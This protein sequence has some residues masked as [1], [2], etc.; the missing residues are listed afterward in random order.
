MRARGQFHLLMWLAPLAALLVHGPSAAALQPSPRSVRVQVVEYRSCGNTN[1]SV[2]QDTLAFDV[3][4][5]QPFAVDRWTDGLRPRGWSSSLTLGSIVGADQAWVRIH[6]LALEAPR[7]NDCLAVPPA[8]S[9]LLTTAWST[10]FGKATRAAGLVGLRIR[11]LPSPA[12]ATMK[13]EQRLDVRRRAGVSLGVL[14]VES[15]ACGSV[16]IGKFRL[17][18]VHLAAP[19]GDSMLV[20]P[21]DAPAAS[22]TELVFTPMELWHGQLPSTD[23]QIHV[24][25]PPGPATLRSWTPGGF[26]TPL[27]VGQ[28]AILFVSIWTGVEGTPPLEMDGRHDLCLLD[29][30]EHL[31]FG[32]GRRGDP[33]EHLRA[34][35]ERAL[36]PRTHPGQGRVVGIVVRDSGPPDCSKIRLSVLGTQFETGLSPAGAFDLIGVPTGTRQIRLTEMGRSATGTIEV[37]EDP[38]DTLEVHFAGRHD[39]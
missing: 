34:D 8:D 37:T 7:R 12:L 33:V 11:L 21:D 39:H 19:A 10:F 6:E 38:T 14:P 32:L 1:R 29:A 5:L 9:V 26:V 20:V 17:D 15:A 27:L 24:H 28:S 22:P 31:A 30:S 23:H 3:K 16:M 25:V 35:V 18:E 2:C 36:W 13:G 4:P